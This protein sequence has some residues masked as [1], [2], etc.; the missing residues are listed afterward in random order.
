VIAFIIQGI[1]SISITIIVN[2]YFFFARLLFCITI[3]CNKNVIILA[4]TS[5]EVKKKIAFP[6]ESFV[7]FWIFWIVKEDDFKFIKIISD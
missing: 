5:F 4:K 1:K 6:L 2:G 3:L 7:R